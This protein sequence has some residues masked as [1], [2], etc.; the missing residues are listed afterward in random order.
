MSPSGKACAGDRHDGFDRLFLVLQKIVPDALHDLIGLL[1]GRAGRKHGLHQQDSLILI[2]KIGRGHAKEQKPHGRHNQ[3][4]ND[5]VAQFFR[6]RMTDQPQI[7]VPGS[8]ELE[9][10]PSE[11]RSQEVDGVFRRLVPLKHRLEERRAENRRQDQGHRHRKEHGGDDGHG[12]LAVDDAG[13]AGE[14]RHGAEDRREHEPDADQGARDLIHGLAG[15]LFGG[16]SFLAHDPLHILHD[17]DGIV[18]QQ[19]DGQHHGKHGQHVNGKP[20]K[21]QHRKGS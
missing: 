21:P 12:E 8:K 13:G 5:K 19:A 18:D 3:Q 15:G 16:E 11:K 2:G 9:I 10:E 7:Q 1:Q 6:K 14:E 4:E 20:E 17:H